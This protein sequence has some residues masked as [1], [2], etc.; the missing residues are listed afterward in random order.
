MRFLAAYG[1]RPTL[2]STAPLISRRCERGRTSTQHPRRTT[3]PRAKVWLHDGR[4]LC[5]SSG[6]PSIPLSGT[7]TRRNATDT[8]RLRSRYSAFGDG[9]PRPSTNAESF[10]ARAASPHG[11]HPTSDRFFRTA[12]RQPPA[13][14]Q[15]SPG[16]PAEPAGSDPPPA[17]DQ[18]RSAPEDAARASDVHALDQPPVAACRGIAAGTR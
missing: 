13:R 14:I 18:P 12:R 6:L 5:F 11:H 4:P 10:F 16:K 7:P 9:H 17:G 3:A 2:R 1:P 8:R 15:L